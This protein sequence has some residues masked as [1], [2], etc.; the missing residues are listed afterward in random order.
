MLLC[1]VV[2]CC[3]AVAMLMLCYRYVVV[4][5]LLCYGALLRVV[6]RVRMIVCHGVSCCVMLFDVV[7]YRVLL[8]GVACYCYL[9]C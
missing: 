7:L 2:C 6:I 9:L 4:L 5:L 8:R 3:D 1:V